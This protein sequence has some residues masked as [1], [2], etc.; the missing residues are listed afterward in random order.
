MLRYILIGFAFYFLYRF[1]FELVIP[2]Y[3]TTKQV[4]K[5]FDSVKQQHT[6]NNPS[7]RTTEKSTS[8]KPSINKDDYI[9][10]EDV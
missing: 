3:R 2:I 4:K 5:Q 8:H 6:Q 10:F 1:I 9:E 7:Q